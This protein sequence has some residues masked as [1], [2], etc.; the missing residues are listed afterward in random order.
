MPNQQ[1]QMKTQSKKSRM[2]EEGLKSKKLEFVQREKEPNQY[3]LRIDN[4]GDMR[5]MLYPKFVLDNIEF[6]KQSD[7][8]VLMRITKTSET[9]QSYKLLYTGSNLSSLIVIDFESNV[10][11]AGGSRNVDKKIEYKKDDLKSFLSEILEKLHKSN[12]KM[13]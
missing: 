1:Q 7:T 9:D 8:K 2:R 12:V 10:I 11:H 3:Q 4:I 6:C 13:M 5:K